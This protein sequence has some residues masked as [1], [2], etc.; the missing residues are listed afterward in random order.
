MHDLSLDVSPE[1]RA[2]CPGDIETPLLQAQWGH[3]VSASPAKIDRT[4][5]FRHLGIT[6]LR[7]SSKGADVSVLK[8]P[9]SQ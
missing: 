4:G 2:R 3:E 9:A 5:H 8:R 7:A 6:P 1:S